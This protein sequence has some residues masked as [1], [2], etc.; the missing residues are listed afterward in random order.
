MRCGGVN[1]VCYPK[2]ISTLE[3]MRSPTANR[4]VGTRAYPC[5]QGNGWYVTTDTNYD[6]YQ[7]VREV[8][9]AKLSRERLARH[10][11]INENFMKRRAEI[12]EE[13]SE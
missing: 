13:R 4:E 12:K 3:T 6:F 8:Q 7:A 2:S 1:K 11:T 10:M 5:P 9:E